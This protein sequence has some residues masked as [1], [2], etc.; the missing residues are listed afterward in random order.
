MTEVIVFPSRRS[1]VWISLTPPS[2]KTTSQATVARSATEC[3][4]F[5]KRPLTLPL[6]SRPLLERA[7]LRRNV[8]F[9]RYWFATA[10]SMAGSSVSLV[11]LPIL[12][13]DALGA[14]SLWIA[15]I[16]IAAQAPGLVLALPAA[17]RSGRYD[18]PFAWLCRTEMMVACATLVIPILYAL[19]MLSLW[20]LVIL[21][22]LEA[23]FKTLSSV[24]R[25][26]A[27]S[28]TVK[29]EDMVGGAGSMAAVSSASSVVGSG[30]AALFTRFSTTAV[31]LV[32][33]GVSTLVGVLVLRT[34]RGLDRAVPIVEVVSPTEPPRSSRATM[35]RNL[36]QYDEV[37]ALVAV[38][39]MGGVL[40]TV[41]LVHALRTL[42]IDAGVVALMLALG[43]IG[44]VAGGA[45]ASTLDRRAPSALMPWAMAVY[46]VAVVPF[47][48]AENEFVGAATLALF[49]LLSAAAGT[50]TIAVAFG[51]LQR[52][53]VDKT[54]ASTM[55]AASVATQAAALMGLAT[56]AVL[57][58][59]FT[60][61]LVLIVASLPVV[62]TISVLVLGSA[63]G[64]RSS[65]VT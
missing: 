25:P 30:I 32:A 54:L 4:A 39:S 29:P 1:R 22:L 6:G 3:Y 49:E 15:A 10:V 21:V 57:T 18:D 24:V 40:E 20:G 27:V 12:A 47:A 45:V 9:R 58:S 60:D 44:G 11:A 23:T 16:G 37:R 34:L 8:E 33:D 5:R 63:Q 43:A 53:T 50:V 42:K 51:R 2:E 7:L 55:A 35:V 56:G 17:E 14:T 19:S 52:Q 13:V 48:L 64:R 46:A 41:V 65:P 26:M 59:L 28:M 38:A 36:F 62:V 31:A 61:R